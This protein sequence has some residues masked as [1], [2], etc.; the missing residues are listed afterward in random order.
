MQCA[1]SHPA[2]VSDT[3]PGPASLWRWRSE[4]AYGNDLMQPHDFTEENTVGRKET[5]SEQLSCIVIY[6]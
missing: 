6:I 4:C 5:G 3:G 2:S 1:Q